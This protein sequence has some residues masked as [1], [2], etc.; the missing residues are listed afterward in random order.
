MQFSNAFNVPPFPSHG[1][2]RRFNPYSAHH[3][4]PAVC[5]SGLSPKADPIIVISSNPD[6]AWRPFRPE[7]LKSLFDRP[8]NWQRIGGEC[9]DLRRTRRL[10]SAEKICCTVAVGTPTYSKQEHARYATLPSQCRI[11]ISIPLDYVCPLGILRAQNEIKN[12]LVIFW[13]SKEGEIDGWID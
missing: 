6:P 1:R 7:P 5:E 8:N 4:L 2:G 3:E 11:A 13:I 12:Y 10:Q 9:I